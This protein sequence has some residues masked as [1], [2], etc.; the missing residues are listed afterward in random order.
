MS[1]MDILEQENISVRREERMAMHTTFRTGG[2]AE[3]LVLP[4]SVEELKRAVQVCREAGVPFR[5]LGKGSN[6]LVADEGLRGAV[7]GTENLVDI[8]EDG[9]KLFVLAGTMLS[10]VAQR[11]CE[12]GLAGLDFAYG[13]PGTVGGAVV[14]NAGAYGGEIKDVLTEAVVLTADGQVKNVTAEDLD[15]SYRH[16]CVEEKGWIVLAVTLCCEPGDTAEIRRK[17]D[18]HMAAR[19][20]KQPL[21][22]PSAGSTFKRPE[23]M[24]AG[25]LIQDAG[26]AG[27]TVGGARVSEKHCGFVISDGTATTADVLAVIRHVQEMVEEKDHVRLECEVKMWQE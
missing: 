13:I 11:A 22:F 8:Q 5:M 6:L 2:P 1:W 4:A 12:L 27:Y 25:K 19:K 17:M 18:E 21:E 7:I 20:E 15:L 9:Q 14:M 23:G 16:S 3:G 24:F 26:L 10:A